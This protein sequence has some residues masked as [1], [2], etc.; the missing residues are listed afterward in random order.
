M[1]KSVA[2]LFGMFFLVQ[3]TARAETTYNRDFA[4][5]VAGALN[6]KT[7][8]TDRSYSQTSA[9][10][11]AYS[12]YSIARDFTLRPGIRFGY[13]WGSPDQLSA[14]SVSISEK[15][16]KG[17]AEITLIWKRI[18]VFPALTFGAGS[19]YRSTSLQTGSTIINTDSNSIS[20]SSFLPF[21]NSQFSLI[22]PIKDGTF[23][24][25]PFVRHT[26]ILGD[27]RTDWYYGLE[28]SLRV[29]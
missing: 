27:H 6:S 14:S 11:F 24:L 19:I 1:T 13:T 2:L 5:G 18:S 26:R 9:E 12:Y 16:A 22:L 23:E 15:D 17:S 25:A 28:A 7:Y 21:L 20:G 4:I 29:F 3:N 10:A 8:G